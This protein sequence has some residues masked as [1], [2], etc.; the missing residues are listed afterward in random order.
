MMKWGEKKLKPIQGDGLLRWT[1]KPTHN[2]VTVLVAQSCPT[3]CDP[4]NC[5]PAVHGILQARILEEVAIPFSR[6]SSRPRDQTRASC[7]AGSFFTV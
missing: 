5:S 2:E 4:K 6:G 3:L 7:I 1:R